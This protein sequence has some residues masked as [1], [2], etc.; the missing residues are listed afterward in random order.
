MFVYLFNP[1]PD[2]RADLNAFA[3]IGNDP[4]WW[5]GN[6]VAGQYYAK[7]TIMSDDDLV[8]HPVEPPTLTVVD[9]DTTDVALV[10]HRQLRHWR[11]LQKDY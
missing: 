6:G 8:D 1:T 4:Y 9:A 7:V 11:C 5:L 2:I 3:Y 10:A